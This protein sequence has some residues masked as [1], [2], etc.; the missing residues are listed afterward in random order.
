M[1]DPVT[2]Y[3]R[4]LYNIAYHGDFTPTRTRKHRI[5]MN[6]F[7]TPKKN[8]TSQLTEIA[9]HS[10]LI[11]ASTWLQSYSQTVVEPLSIEPTRILEAKGLEDDYYLNL[12]DWSSFTNKIAIGLLKEVYLWCEEGETTNFLVRLPDE[13]TVASVSWKPGDAHLAIGTKKGKLEIIDSDRGI[14]VR[15]LTGH[16]KHRTGTVHWNPNQP[17]ILSSGGRDKIICNFI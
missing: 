3:D 17:N 5:I 14:S 2:P 13:D 9:R 8:L 1:I 6:S 7:E 10:S 16:C 11:E 4:L 12:L 15:R